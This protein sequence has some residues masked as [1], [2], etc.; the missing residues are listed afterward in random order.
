[1]IRYL[2]MEGYIRRMYYRR[3]NA[4]V[5]MMLMVGI[6]GYR[7]ENRLYWEMNLIGYFDVEFEGKERIYS[8][9]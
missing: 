6:L 3:K 1:M 9:F 7:E 5:R 4:R 8:V 2:C